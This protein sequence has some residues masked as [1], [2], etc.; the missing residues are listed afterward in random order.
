M[1]NSNDDDQ[2]AQS[3]RSNIRGLPNAI[4]LSPG[5][6]APPADTSEV[7][8]GSPVR[9]APRLRRSG[10][11]RGP[12]TSSGRITKPLSNAAAATSAAARGGADA[13]VVP[14]LGGLAALMA[15]GAVGLIL[16]SRRRS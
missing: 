9:H 16:M 10:P 5:T 14:M 3:R 6:S 7:V 8:D 15:L 2:E 11:K 4:T 12:G 1:S 13:I